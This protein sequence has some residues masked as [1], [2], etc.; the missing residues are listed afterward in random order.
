MVVESLGKTV[1]KITTRLEVA[2]ATQDIPYPN[3]V[4]KSGMVG[5]QHYEWTFWV[6]GA[7][8]M[9][10]HFYWTM[11][12]H[13]DPLWDNGDSCYRVVIHGDPPLEMRL[14]G[15]VAED[16]RRPFLGLPWTA[17]VGCTALPAVCDAA[18]GIITHLDLGVV[19]PRGLVRP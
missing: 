6:D 1:E 19:Q 2:K 11:G 9:I 3:G 5:G 17:L 13:L 14:M 16:G 15:G 18:P 7:P 10:Y 12:E 4:I 8:F